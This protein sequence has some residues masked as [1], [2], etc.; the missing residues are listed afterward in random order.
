MIKKLLEALRACD[1][2]SSPSYRER[3]QGGERT[4]TAL[5]R[6][7]IMDALD[8]CYPPLVEV[9]KVFEAQREKKKVAY[10][11]ALID[12]VTDMK[13]RGLGAG[14]HREYRQWLTREMLRIERKHGIR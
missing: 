10:C 3:I 12:G 11:A 2:A 13:S 9:V 7:E 1:G 8:R 4:P 6:L 5:R 14:K